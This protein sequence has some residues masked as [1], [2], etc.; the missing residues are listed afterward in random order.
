MDAGESRCKHGRLGVIS[1]AALHPTAFSKKFELS[2]DPMLW[3]FYMSSL[4]AL[5][6]VIDLLLEYDLFILFLGFRRADT[7][8]LL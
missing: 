1:R 6:L 2:I 5:T 8:H 7:T 3:C 4:I